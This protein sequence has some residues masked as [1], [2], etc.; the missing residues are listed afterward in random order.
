MRRHPLPLIL[1]VFPLAVG[2]DAIEEP[3]ADIGQQ[4]GAIVGGQ[5][6][7]GDPAVPYILTSGD[8]SGACSGTLISP[9][10]VLTA[11]HCVD[12]GGPVTS[13]S[14]YFGTTR[15]GS[16]AGEIQTI[17]GIMQDYDPNWSLQG[18][19]IALILLER[20]SN[21]A[22]IGINRTP[23][24]GGDIGR[25][26]RIVGWGETASSDP[27][28]VKRQVT[29]SITDIQSSEVFNYGNSNANTC[30][31]DSGGPSFINRSGTEVVAGV[32]SWGTGGCFGTSGAMRV[33]QHQSFIDAFIRD[34]DIQIPPDVEFAR[35][36]DGDRVPGF[37]VV[38]ANA[39]DNIEVDRVEVYLDNQLAETLTLPPFLKNFTDVADGDHTLTLTAYDNYGDS[40]TATINIV[41]DSS[42]DTSD[43]CPGG[44]TCEDNVC[45][46][47]SGLLGDDCVEN[48]DCVTGLCGQTAGGDRFCTEHC[49]VAGDSCPGGFE[50]SDSGDGTGFCT[51]AG[52][53][54]SAGGNGAGSPLLLMLVTV[55]L[56]AIRRRRRDGDLV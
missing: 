52:G 49:E 23:L 48:A 24:T 2:C 47:S 17:A 54:C 21:V 5:V 8:E 42:C 12:L 10:V 38:E 1:A 27:A 9:R 4:T 41:V 11:A 16:D 44:A 7:T 55:G 6:N 39:T 13:Q 20:E 40:D 30:Q 28:G 26:I 33:A 43:D 56:L 36:L 53:G 22:P 50:C 29:A 46:P 25:S 19:D 51:P 15:V 31:G 14:V 32:T 35:P 45:V 18:G 34:N 3:E 37:F